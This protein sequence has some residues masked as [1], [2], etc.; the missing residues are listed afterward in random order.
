MTNPRPC[1]LL[2]FLL[3]LDVKNGIIFI[4]YRLNYRELARIFE[5]C[6]PSD[7]IF[8]ANSR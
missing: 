2:R 4:H 5:N 3:R 8:V 1:T 6:V 7:G